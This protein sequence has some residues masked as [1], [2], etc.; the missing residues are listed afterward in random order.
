MT[1][2]AEA[3]IIVR[4]KTNVE[5]RG[6]ARAHN[7]E[8]S[9]RRPINHRHPPNFSLPKLLDAQFAKLFPH[10]TFLLYGTI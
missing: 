5:T 3:D 8:I 2:L 10:Q 6:S 1:K 4:H 9:V 7:Q